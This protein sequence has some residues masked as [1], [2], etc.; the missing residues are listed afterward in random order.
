M[1]PDDALVRPSSPQQ[2]AQSVGIEPHE[3]RPVRGSESGYRSQ[4]SKEVL[5]PC[6]ERTGESG[7]VS[8]WKQGGSQG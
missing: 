8:R 4:V 5:D 2:L 1:R 6:I 3:A 7:I